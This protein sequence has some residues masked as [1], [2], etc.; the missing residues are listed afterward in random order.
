MDQTFHDAAWCALS[1]HIGSGREHPEG[2]ATLSVEYHQ[3]CDLRWANSRHPDQYIWCDRRQWGEWLADEVPA[4]QFSDYDEALYPLLTA[5]GFAPAQAFF[6]DMQFTPGELHRDALAAGWQVTLTLRQQGRSLPLILT[7]WPWQA[8]LHKTAHWLRW[9]APP[10]PLQ[11]AL[12][13]CVGYGKLTL[14]QLLAL[15][16]NDGI[17]LQTAAKIVAGQVWLYLQE[18]R[19]IM[20]LHDSDAEIEHIGAD[21][22][23]ADA[24]VPGMGEI[25][26]T[27]MAEVGRMQLS[28]AQLARLAPGAL[29]PGECSLSGGVRL[30]VNGCCIGYGSLVALQ[31]SWLVRVDT[32]TGGQIM[33]P[34]PEAVENDATALENPGGGD[35]MA[36]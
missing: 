24:A 10:P 11:V 6:E 21:P 23:V 33:R 34:Q 20:T 30:T 16:A 17:V 15:Q 8:L 35:G 32:L 5:L 25:P 22:F 28:L 31:D 4:G 7:H 18:K 29:L 1:L 13:L 14:K 12:P 19:V 27:V 26:M 2:V 3:G 9:D 36:G